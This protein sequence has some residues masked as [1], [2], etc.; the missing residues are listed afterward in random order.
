[1]VLKEKLSGLGGTWDENQ[2]NR[3][4]FRLNGGIMN[5]YESTGALNFQG[6]EDKR[7]ILEKKVKDILFLGDSSVP[8]IRKGF[9]KSSGSSKAVPTVPT[10]V[11]QYLAG[12]F[13][14]SELIFGIVSAVGT[15]TKRVTDP[16]VDRIQGYGYNV[17]Q[18]R[19]SDLLKKPGQTF[20]NEYE[21]IKTFIKIGDRVRAKSTANAN[22]SD[23]ER[24]AL[25]AAGV[26]GEIRKLR[27]VERPRTAY[28]VNSLKHPDEVDFL[29]KIYGE[30]F[31]VIGIHCDEKRR[32]KYLIEDKGLKQSE[33][34]ELTLIDQDEDVKHGQ[35]TRDTFHLADFFINVGKDSDQVKNTIDRFLEIIFSN[36]YRNPTFDEFAMFM[37]FCSSISSGDLSRQVGAIVARDYQILAT[38]A[39]ECPASGGGHYWAEVDRKTGEV[40]DR[41]EGKDYTWE[42]DSNK[43]EQGEIIHEIIDKM[44]SLDGV[45]DSLKVQLLKILTESRI[46]DITE[47]GRVVHAEMDALLSCA[48]AGIS[49]KSTTLYCTTFPCHNCAKH[50]I[51]AGVERVVYVEPYPKSKALELHADSIKLKTKLEEEDDDE[52]KVVFEPFTGVGARRFLDLFSM[53]LGAGPKLKRKDDNGNIL[54]WNKQNARVRSPVLQS[55]YN[56]AE[57]EAAELFSLFAEVK[58]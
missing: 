55:S 15:E 31:F 30:C 48:R 7:F 32:L 46:R 22:L 35:K 29:R 51:D 5:W 17:E 44:S 4:V 47:F 36:P 21:R 16:L 45:S 53:N 25:L 11:S 40:N 34:L 43:V 52:G 39:N 3:K 56:D 26:V 58:V 41:P 2:P 13:M 9:N 33:A 20:S 42:A 57:A 6:K 8:P 37:A 54:N 38:G 14:D 28:L 27:Q 18:I 1:M 23:A 24:N 50:L 49:T 10:V 19:V 12:E